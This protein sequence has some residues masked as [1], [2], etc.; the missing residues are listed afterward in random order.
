MIFADVMFYDVVKFFH[1]LAIVLAF[2]PT[3]SYALFFTF[4]SKDPRAM[5]AV[6]KSASTWDRT[7]GTGGGV[8]AIITGIYLVSDT[9]AYDFSNFFV[10]WGFVAIII[11]IGMTHAFFIPQTV[12][13]G[14]LAERDLKASG[15]GEPKL[16]D[17]FN[18]VADRLNK[19][20]PVAGLIVVLTIYVMSA[21]PF[22]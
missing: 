4:A 19:L 10:S 18:A 21:K 22:L 11:L 3:F 8:L 13:A 5:P 12:K 20:G 2:G 1:I 9:G 7:V 6:A 14:K 15:A 16:S 17:E